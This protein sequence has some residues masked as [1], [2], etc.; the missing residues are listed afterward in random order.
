[1]GSLLHPYLT[2]TAT[3]AADGTSEFSAVY[4]ATV[5]YTVYL[6][7]VLRAAS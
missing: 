5:L 3:A 7:V 6:P 1:V 2:A 4:T